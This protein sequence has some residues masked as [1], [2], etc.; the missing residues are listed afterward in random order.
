VIHFFVP[1][2]DG[3]SIKDIFTGWGSEVD[4]QNYLPIPKEAY[5]LRKQ[6]IVNIASSIIG[7]PFMS[8]VKE[9]IEI[10]N[11]KVTEKRNM[12]VEVDA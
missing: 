4:F 7:E 1:Q 11:Q 2:Y 3:L 12:L 6:V 8:W 9:R 5:R 10:R